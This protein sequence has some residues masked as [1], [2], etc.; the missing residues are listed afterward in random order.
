[1]MI[2]NKKDIFTVAH[3]IARRVENKTIK[4]MRRELD[5]PV[6]EL[7]NMFV[8][9]DLARIDTAW[10]EIMIHRIYQYLKAKSLGVLR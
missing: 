8:E 2:L 10:F 5:C 9:M 4:E 7:D 6:S 1:M 3:G